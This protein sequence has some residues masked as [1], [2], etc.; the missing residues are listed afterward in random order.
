MVPIQMSPVSLALVESIHGHLTSAYPIGPA[1]VTFSIYFCFYIYLKLS[2]IPVYISLQSFGP[3]NVIMV[4]VTNHPF[5][6][7]P[8]VAS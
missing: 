7:R 2:S 3:P 5:A 8:N 4:G 6:S 1:I